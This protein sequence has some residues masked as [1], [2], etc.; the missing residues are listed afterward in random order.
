M[1]HEGKK[2]SKKCNICDKCF[3][4]PKDLKRHTN[5]VHEK[6]KAFKCEICLAVFGRKGEMD[7]HINDS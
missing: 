2:P 4:G 6:I 7:N 1:A 3:D 5:T